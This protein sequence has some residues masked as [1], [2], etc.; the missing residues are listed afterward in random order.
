VKRPQY[1]RY[2]LRLELPT[3]ARPV[4]GWTPGAPGASSALVRPEAFDDWSGV[5]AYAPG[6]DGQELDYAH[7][8]AVRAIV[9]LQPAGWQEEDGG[10]TLVF[11][12]EEG[13]EARSEVAASLKRLGGL[14]RLEVARERPGWEDAWRR[15][16]KPHVIG[17]LYVRPPW[18]PP[19]DDLL[20]IAV[21]AGLAFGTGGHASTR[22]CLELIQTIKPGSLLDLGSGSGVVSFAALRLGFAPV[23][24]IDIDPVAVHAA[25]GN[26]AMNDLAPT[27]L[28][29][30]ATDPAYP[31]PSADVVVA[32]IALRP[33]LRL[34]ERWRAAER[35][36]T[37][38]PG[39]G[40]PD[41]GAPATRAGMAPPAQ[42]LLSGLLVEQAD[43]ALAAF[44]AFAETARADDGTWLTLRLTRRV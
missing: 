5:A 44:P 27:F 21:E 10:R 36:W 40:D 32:N 23:T 16:H 38:G 37:V 17:R 3:G 2:A 35:A 42:L 11:W 24:G 4:A 8:D 31:L 33:I 19:R 26:A 29:G 34:A 25:A 28:V 30:D 15:F 20:D 7:P 6:P 43:E 22:E 39:S 1:T 18:Y 12:L 41:S 9:D 14:G 13:A